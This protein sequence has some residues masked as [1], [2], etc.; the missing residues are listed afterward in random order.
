DRAAM[1][2][3]PDG[4]RSKA[5]GSQFAIQARQLGAHRK[6]S[7]GG[8]VGLPRVAFVCAEQ[9]EQ[10][11]TDELGDVAVMGHEY[12]ARAC[13]IIV[14]HVDE[15]R[16]VGSFGQCA[17]ADQVGEQ[18]RHVLAR[19]VR[20]FVSGGDAIDDGT[21]RE[22]RECSL[23]PLELACRRVERAAQSPAKAP[24]ARP[25]DADS[26]QKE[27]RRSDDDAHASTTSSRHTAFA[28]EVTPMTSMYCSGA[29][30]SHRARAL[31]CTRAGLYRIVSRAKRAT[32]TS[33]SLMPGAVRF[34]S[35]DCTCASS[36]PARTSSACASR[37]ATDAPRP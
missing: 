4:K 11:V 3:D 13:E 33:A 12:P 22:A 7:I 15:D 35:A 21:R 20:C 14:E 6:R 16:G 5:A 30:T 37:S 23:Q 8:V 9:R 18:N 25:R 34:A 27:Y 31:R 1:N 32:A 17:R 2:P 24:F 28:S 19:G 26:N 36:I 10:T 29:S